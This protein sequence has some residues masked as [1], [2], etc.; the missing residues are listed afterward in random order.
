MGAFFSFNFFSSL[1]SLVIFGIHVCTIRYIPCSPSLAWQ[2]GLYIFYEHAFK[3]DSANQALSLSTLPSLLMVPNN[4]VVFIS[5]VLFRCH[6]F[7][8][9]YAA[10]AYDKHCNTQIVSTKSSF[11]RSYTYSADLSIHE[12]TEPKKKRKKIVRIFTQIFNKLVGGFI[13]LFQCFMHTDVM[14]GWTRKMSIKSSN[15]YCS[16]IMF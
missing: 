3:I 12:K 9:R 1:F 4:T 11:A 7:H 14:G 5:L 6:Y 13:K 10:L 16:D 8:R 2:D 15:Y